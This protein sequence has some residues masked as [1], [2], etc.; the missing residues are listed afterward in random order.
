MILERSHLD[1]LALEMLEGGSRILAVAAK[2]SKETGA[3]VLGGVAVFLHGYRRTTEDVDVFAVDERSVAEALERLGAA[4]DAEGRQHVL[5]GVPV[6]IVTAS[7]C[8]AAPREVEELA[9][10]RVVG[11]ADLI[12]FKLHSGLDRV[13]RSRDLADVVEL[14]RRVPLDKSFAPRLP[15]EMRRPFKD[16]VDAVHGQGPP[17]A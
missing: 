1:E 13:E 14:I 7:Q 4:W 2:V 8:G 9:G 15:R 3:P 5:D 11:L 6:H 12:R 16:L 10:V 17:A